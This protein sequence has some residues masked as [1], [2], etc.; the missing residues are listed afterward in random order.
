MYVLAA[1][2]LMLHST[3]NFSVVILDELYLYEKNHGMSL[4]RLNFEQSSKG[5]AAYSFEGNEIQTEK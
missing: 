2:Y 4:T 3:V 1:S 5:H